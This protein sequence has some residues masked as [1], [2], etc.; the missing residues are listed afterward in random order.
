M[1]SSTR[2]GSALDAAIVERFYWMS[3]LQYQHMAFAG[4]LEVSCFNISEVLCMA[5]AS[6]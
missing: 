5:F 2:G 1:V 6:W 3:M 4:L